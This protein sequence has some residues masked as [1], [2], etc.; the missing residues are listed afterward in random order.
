MLQESQGSG[1]ARHRHGLR[2]VPIHAAPP[3]AALPIQRPIRTVHN[4]YHADR[5][6]AGASRGGD[7]AVDAF[8]GV[9]YRGARGPRA[10]R[11]SLEFLTAGLPKIHMGRR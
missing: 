9:P 11:E 7:G 1:S 6:A 3:L 4:T 2:S 10:D 5:T 8:G